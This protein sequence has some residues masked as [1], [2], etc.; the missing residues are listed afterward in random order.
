LAF[1]FSTCFLSW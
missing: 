1:C